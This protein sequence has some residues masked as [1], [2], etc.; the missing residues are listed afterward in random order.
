MHE[1]M[2]CLNFFFHLLA[3]LSLPRYTYRDEAAGFCYC[4]DVVLALLRLQTHFT[5]VLYIDMDVHHGDG[6]DT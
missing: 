1:G 3:S 6:E 2:V 4:N 5:R